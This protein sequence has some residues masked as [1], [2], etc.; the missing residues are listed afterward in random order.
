MLR[1]VFY[2]WIPKTKQSDMTMYHNFN[3]MKICPKEVG[4][5]SSRDVCEPGG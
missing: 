2:E 5:N 4:Q 1:G 3:D